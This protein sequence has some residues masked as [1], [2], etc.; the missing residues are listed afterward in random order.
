MNNAV[1]YLKKWYYFS[2]VVIAVGY[3]FV[4]LS[5]IRDWPLYTAALVAFV[6]GYQFKSML[7]YEFSLNSLNDLSAIRK[8]IDKV[9]TMSKTEDKK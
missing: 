7:M 3:S 6:V 1:V 2:M 9:E 8:V 4:L 5:V